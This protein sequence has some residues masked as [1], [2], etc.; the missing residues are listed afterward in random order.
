MNAMQTET[1]DWSL[2]LT[3]V[4][5]SLDGATLRPTTTA[6]EL[7][8]VELG[9]ASRKIS[10]GTTL[11]REASRE[12]PDA[13]SRVPRSKGPS[14]L[15]LRRA[16]RPD[17]KVI[18]AVLKDGSG[19]TV[20]DDEFSGRDGMADLGS[21]LR[22]ARVSGWLRAVG[23]DA[24][25]KAEAFYTPGADSALI[26]RISS[27]NG[28]LVL[29][30]GPLDVVRNEVAFTRRVNERLAAAGLSP[31]FPDQIEFGTEGKLGISLMESVLPAT[32][33]CEVFLDTSM[34]ELNPDF[35]AVLA[36]HLAALEVLHASSSIERTP[37]MGSYIYRD[38]FDH[39]ANDPGF[40]ESFRLYFA[41]IELEE[42][43]DA[44]W[45]DSDGTR[46]EGLT[47]L[48]KRLAAQTDLLTPSR[49]SLIHGD[50]HLKN[51]LR[52][53]DRS[54]V[55]IDPRTIWDGNRRDDEGYGDPAYD[56]ATLLHSVWP[57]SSIL[58]A[59][60]RKRSESLLSFELRGRDYRVDRRGIPPFL[61]RIEMALVTRLTRVEGVDQAARAR[62]EIGAANALMGWLKYPN[63]LPTREAWTAT[64]LAMLDYLTR[65]LASIE[66]V[67]AL[68]TS[69][70]AKGADTK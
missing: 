19:A 23:H 67:A 15:Q 20:L 16:H 47:S 63:A 44:A 11:T 65:G 46:V 24:K 56:L 48:R 22:D 5:S 26:A 41:D 45:I 3:F 35:D 30:V 13:A 57:M 7:W 2:H 14:S 25:G 33:D 31:L 6:E 58:Q 29:K 66:A 50:A 62:L 9:V 53:Q 61:D 38:R 32:L 34:T 21:R 51:M 70:T 36:P 42:F 49:S 52:R 17:S 68:S 12:N 27:E 60:E 28:P 39:V 43:L 40:L 37:S 1:G 18:C 64:Y 8:A 4:S 10:V 59:I 55:F 54:P 69:T